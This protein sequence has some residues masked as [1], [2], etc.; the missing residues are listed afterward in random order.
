[1]PLVDKVILLKKIQQFFFH[2]IFIFPNFF[3]H[4]FFPALFFCTFYFVGTFIFMH[5]GFL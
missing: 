5:F 3:L 1:M 4:V 2:A